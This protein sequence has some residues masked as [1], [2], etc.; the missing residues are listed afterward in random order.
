[1]KVYVSIHNTNFLVSYFLFSGTK[2]GLVDANRR[3]QAWAVVHNRSTI[4][5]RPLQQGHIVVEIK[6][7]LPTCQLKPLCPGAFDDPEQIQRGEF[8]CWPLTSVAL[9]LKST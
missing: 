9:P 2:V 8:H 3:V 1:M 6:D 5:G 7:V 4:H